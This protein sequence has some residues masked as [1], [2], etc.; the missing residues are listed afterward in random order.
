MFFEDPPEHEALLEEARERYGKTA[1]RA[2]ALAWAS[3]MD[4]WPADV[5]ERDAA[6]LKKAGTIENLVRSLQDTTRG[7]RINTQRITAVV[8]LVPELAD[9]DEFQELTRLLLEMAEE[10]MKVRT[11]AAFVPNGEPPAMGASEEEMQPAI[12]KLLLKPYSKGYILLLPEE[13]VREEQRRSGRTANF[14]GTGWAESANKVEG[15]ITI[16]PSHTK[17]LTASL[18]LPRDETHRIGAEQYGVHPYPTLRDLIRMILAA[19]IL[20]DGDVF[21]LKLDMQGAFHLLDFSPESVRLMCSRVRGG[22]V[23]LWLV[24]NF[25]HVHTPYAFGVLSRFLEMVVNQLGL[26]EGCLFNLKIYVDDLMAAVKG[27]HVQ[28]AR[29]TLE[30]VMRLL[31]GDNSVATDKTEWGKA[32]TLIGWDTDLVARNVTMSRKTLLKALYLFS[33]VSPAGTVAYEHLEV[34]AA[35]TERFSAVAP[36]LAGFRSYLYGA[37]SWMNRFSTVTLDDTA[38]TALRLVKSL[39]VRHLSLAGARYS[40]DFFA[41]RRATWVVEYDGSIHGIGGRVFELVDGVEHLRLC[42]SLD[43]PESIAAHPDRELI[44]NGCELLAASVSVAAILSLGV[45]DVGLHL[46][47]DSV[48]SGSWLSA[49]RYKSPFSKNSSLLWLT[50]GQSCGLSMEEW[51]HLPKERNTVCDAYSRRTRPTSH[52]CPPHV[53]EALD[54]LVALCNPVASRAHFESLPTLN[55]F[56]ADLSVSLSALVPSL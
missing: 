32:L 50:F 15:R 52:G 54:S 56:L 3:D 9:D 23:L 43:L 28:R 55:G 41:P 48:V 18:N 29:E 40:F 5:R 1:G 25:G 20:Y 46:R 39:V 35:L 44:Q 36:E 21:L 53:I 14:I 27:A 37:Y 6:R 4:G 33:L 45:R 22:M 11:P 38:L 10:G 8:A 7:A 17:P 51:T 34:L 12:C 26:R 13:E 47:G 19:E 30:G 42:I 49:G 16:N 24:G 2:G 31:L